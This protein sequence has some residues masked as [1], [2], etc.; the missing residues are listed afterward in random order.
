MTAKQFLKQGYR[1]N[2]FI[3][4]DKLQL[5][6]LHELAVSLQSP[7]RSGTGSP[8]INKDKILNNIERITAL[9]TKIQNGINVYLQLQEDI[10][11]KINSVQN[12]DYRLILQK[13]YINLLKWEQIAVDLNIDLRWV[14]RLHNKALKILTI[15]SHY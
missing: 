11:S 4:S 3:K 7:C 8:N 1:L 10:K 9:E 13:R 6:V 12:Y 5:Q 2:E 15:E 14:Y